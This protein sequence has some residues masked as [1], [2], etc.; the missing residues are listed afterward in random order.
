MTTGTFDSIVIGGRRFT[1]KADDSVETLLKSKTMDLKKYLEQNKLTES[2]LTKEEV[3]QA[4]QRQLVANYIAS[5][6]PIC[7]TF[8]EIDKIIEKINERA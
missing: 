5:Y 6:S 7:L 8:E 1:I 3:W 2:Q 4:A